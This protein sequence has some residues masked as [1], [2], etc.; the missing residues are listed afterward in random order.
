MKFLFDDFKKLFDL[1][2][3]LKEISFNLSISYAT[4][5]RYK[6][7]LLYNS[8]SLPKPKKKKHLL[9]DED[10]K[11]IVEFY[12]KECNSFN[13]KHYYD[14]IVKENMYF[15]ISFSTL[16]R[17]MKEHNIISPSATKKTK[18]EY[19]KTLYLHNY[20]MSIPDNLNIEV[21]KFIDKKHAF[22]IKP[23]PKYFGQIIEADACTDY[24]ISDDKKHTLHMFVDKSTG[25]VLGA[26]FD[27]QE[28]LKGYFK[29][30][31]QV[32]LNYGIP[33]KLITD[34]R[35][36]F[37]YQLKSKPDKEY[38]TNFKNVC[39]ILGIALITTSNPRGKGTVERTHYSFQ[40]RLPKELRFL[41]IKKI[42]EC[43]EYLL[44][45]IQTFNKSKVQVDYTQNCFIGQLSEEEID[46][47]LC[48]Q[49][50]RK[51]HYSCITFERK[52]YS[53]VNEKGERVYIQDKEYVT[54]LKKLDGSLLIKYFDNIFGVEEIDEV[55]QFS[56]EF[57]IK[58][59][60]E[61]KVY[62][63]P[64]NHPWRYHRN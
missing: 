8:S 36:V 46:N 45:F 55:E 11:Y 21:P 30:F 9:A 6:A 25:I 49:Y 41:N 15:N 31:K 53:P 17:I 64:K 32:L 14:F 34:K 50:Q 37:Y 51:I 12:L 26:S 2:L 40:S 62:I 27:T 52:T 3:S 44:Q 29:A 10:I 22:Q 16:Q 35:T 18:R 58:T 43:E 19:S 23:K 28:T 47:I 5:K 60:K 4:A 57:D 7:K 42:A 20:K 54:V 13:F 56:E 63:P 39:K 1:G 24:W 48:L 33:A 61:K 59:E 38:L